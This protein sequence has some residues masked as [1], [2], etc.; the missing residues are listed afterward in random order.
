MVREQFTV[1]SGLSKYTPIVKKKQ[2][3]KKKKKNEHLWGDWSSVWLLSSR[4]KLISQVSIF[5]TQQGK[6]RKKEKKKS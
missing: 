6:K 2:E 1:Q 3:K 4:S 5:S